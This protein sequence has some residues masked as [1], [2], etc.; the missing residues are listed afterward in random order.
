M[1]PRGRM[2]AR[3]KPAHDEEVGSQTGFYPTAAAFAAPALFLRLSITGGSRCGHARAS[4]RQRVEWIAVLSL[5]RKF[6]V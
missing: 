3:V 4:A 1:P 6:T 5:R 2:D